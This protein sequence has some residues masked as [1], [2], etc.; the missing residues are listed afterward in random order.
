MDKLF[1]YIKVIGYII[2][3]ILISTFIM[4]MLNYFNIISSGTLTYFK[5][6]I[7][8]LSTFLGGINIGKKSAQKGWLEGL[9]LGFLLIFILYLFAYL[10]L[11][12][13]MT[14]KNIIYYI[15]I[16]AMTMLGGM[17][18]INKQETNE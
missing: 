18:G 14:I 3:T 11:E 2:I 5:F 13:S 7:I 15:I 8:L 9:K 10:G 4:T 12:K 6:F 16:L 1:K 17:V